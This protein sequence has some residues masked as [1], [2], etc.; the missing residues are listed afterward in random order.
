MK[1]KYAGIPNQPFED[2]AKQRYLNF[3]FSKP[4]IYTH[5]WYL[6]TKWMIRFYEDDIK[7]IGQNKVK[8]SDLIKYVIRHDELLFDEKMIPHVIH[9]LTAKPIKKGS[10]S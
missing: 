7:R 9:D 6:M 5:D 3:L 1:M 4:E 2:E 10:T 8:L